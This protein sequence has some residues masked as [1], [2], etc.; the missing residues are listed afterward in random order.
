MLIDLVASKLA[1]PPAR[2]APPYKRDPINL[3]KL[4]MGGLAYQRLRILG[5]ALGSVIEKVDD[6]PIQKTKIV[7]K[8][9][10][11]RVTPSGP[12]RR[13]IDLIGARVSDAWKPITGIEGLPI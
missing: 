8:L 2:G 3:C 5:A 6:L 7:S 1:F 11:D 10:A 9:K 12:S 13:K 4:L